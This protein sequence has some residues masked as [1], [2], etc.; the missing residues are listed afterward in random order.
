M[1]KRPITLVATSTRDFVLGSERIGGPAFFAGIALHLLGAEAVIL[2]VEGKAAGRLRRLP[3]IE[4]RAV[5]G[6]EAIF[7]IDVDGRDRTL[8]A[9]ESPELEPEL[10]ADC[11]GP[12]VI[13]GTLGEISL[14]LV[15][16][17]ASRGTTIVDVQGFAR[18]LADGGRVVNSADRVREIM[19]RLRGSGVILRGEKYEFPPECRGES[20]AE[21]SERYR[22]D[23]IVTDSGDPFYAALGGHLYVGHPI[24]GLDGE[25]IGL[26]DVFT[27]ALCNYMCSEGMSIEESLARASAAATL[28]MR[29]KQPWFTPLEVEEAARKVKVLRE[30]AGQTQF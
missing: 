11:G 20:I 16:R 1:Q 22:L 8:K 17:A 23:L 2:T 6:R 19:A 21:C 13:S 26:G 9:L 10:P 5:K 4:V 27:A 28:K 30:P 14:E 24:Q 18:A 29:D 3:G 12:Y 25:P 15:E 7:S